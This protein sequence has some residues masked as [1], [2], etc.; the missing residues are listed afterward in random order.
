MD[1][2]C[3]R[4]N[5]SDSVEEALNKVELSIE[6]HLGHKQTYLFI[7]K[8]ELSQEP[9]TREPKNCSTYD[10]PRTHTDVCCLHCNFQRSLASKARAQVK[11]AQKHRETIDSDMLREIVVG[12]DVS[13]KRSRERDDTPEPKKP[14]KVV[15]EGDMDK[16]APSNTKP[17]TKRARDCDDTPVS[18]ICQD[19]VFG[20]DME[21]CLSCLQLWPDLDETGL[22][23]DCRYS[24]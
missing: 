4:L 21:K 10:Q 18:E 2:K 8:P 14:Q 1:P 24:K 16:F 19:L 17:Q 6:P 9:V 12:G 15:T 7:D 5:L 23:N 22:C 11:R 20:G 13:N 3:D